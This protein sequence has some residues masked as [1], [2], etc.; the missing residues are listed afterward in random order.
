MTTYVELAISKNTSAV[1]L[2]V[3]QQSANQVELKKPGPVEK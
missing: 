1:K 3:L 2:L